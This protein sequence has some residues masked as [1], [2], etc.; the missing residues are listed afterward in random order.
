MIRFCVRSEA[1]QTE[2]EGKGKVTC[3][4]QVSGLSNWNR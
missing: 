4:S 3:N 1:W 2:N